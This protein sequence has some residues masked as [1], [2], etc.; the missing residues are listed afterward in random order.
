MEECAGDVPLP[1][2]PLRV[3][4]VYN[5]KNGAAAAT[6]DDDAE[7]DSPETVEAIASALRA[8]GCEPFALEVNE[9]LPAA[10]LKTR[11]E[12]VFNIAEGV[13]GRGREAE[14]PALLNLLGIP[15]TGSDET[16]LAISLD[17]EL[18]KRV[19]AACGVKTPES[20]VVNS[21]EDLERVSLDYPLIVK[22]NAEGSS[23]GV[24]DA[25]VVENA[26]ALRELAEKNMALYHEPMLCEQYLPGREFTVGILGNGAETRV[27]PPMEIV[28]QRAT[29]GE[30]RVYSFDVK[31]NYQKFISYRCPA[32]ITDIQAEAMRRAALTAFN[33]LG[34]CD[35]ARVDFRMDDAGEPY[36]IEI[37]PLPG[38]APGYSDFP[39]LAEFSGVGYD[40]LVGAVLTAAV[41]R[42]G[43]EARG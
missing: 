12:L 43:L 2:G 39:M 7:Y 15:F 37:N 21:P 20:A 42:L 8:W 22:P 1:P 28:F 16:A 17:K 32:D 3:A 27:F 34:C 38:L 11:P 41:R 25:C 9:N 18:C 14:V 29:Q 35:L 33:A 24:G 31:Q 10:L 4:I 6:A 36:F 5:G 40:A 23:K 19:A 13:R 26:A 30:Y